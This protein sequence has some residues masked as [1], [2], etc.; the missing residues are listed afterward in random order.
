MKMTELKR[1]RRMVRRLAMVEEELEQH[2]VITCT[3]GSKGAPSY[4][5]TT[6]VYEDYPHTERV[7]QLFSQRRWLRAYILKA[8]DFIFSVEDERVCEA[9]I[10]Y[11]IDE[12][13]YEKVLAK[14][15]KRGKRSNSP[16]RVTW[17]DVA[18]EMGETSGDS[19][20]IAVHRY[21][22]EHNAQ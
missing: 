15:K 7:M 3:N 10:L 21:L 13:L 22:N 5:K 6:R 4:E 2:T 20:R 12:R 18:E 1:Y 9:L 11:C 14:A 19:L 17:A 16:V 8:E